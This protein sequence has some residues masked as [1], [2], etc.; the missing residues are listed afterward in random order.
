MVDRC[1][2][3]GE[4][5]PEGSQVCLK[6]MRKILS[7]GAA[8]CSGCGGGYIKDDKARCFTVL[9][10]YGRLDTALID[11]FNSLCEIQKRKA[12]RRFQ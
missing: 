9:H 4:A 10:D 11:S 2:I 5:I 12:T 8:K 6:C 1:I 3:C 7:A